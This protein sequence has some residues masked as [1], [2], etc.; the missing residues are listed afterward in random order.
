MIAAG[1]MS[2]GY[3]S[4][5][6][7]LFGPNVVGRRD[8]FES[9]TAS[10]GTSVVRDSFLSTDSPPPLTT[11]GL[12]FD[13]PDPGLRIDSLLPGPTDDDD[14]DDDSDRLHPPLTVTSYWGEVGKGTWTPGSTPQQQQRVT[15]PTQPEFRH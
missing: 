14:D 10:P 1:T 11:P 3:G 15:R 2:L 4:R 6:L 13:F 9:G 5:H 7:D 8:S 12:F